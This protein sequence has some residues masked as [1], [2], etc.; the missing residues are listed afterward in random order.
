MTVNSSTLPC[1]VCHQTLDLR[2]AQV[3]K[4]GKPSLMLI[5]PQD[6]RHFRGF[7]ADKEY[8]QAVVDRVG[9]VNP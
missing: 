7:I 5:C 6:G 1:P 3:R 2:K 9:E 4:S 8:V